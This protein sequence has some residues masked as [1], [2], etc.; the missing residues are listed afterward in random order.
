MS[1]LAILVFS[2]NFVLCTYGV[3][4]CWYKDTLLQTIGLSITAI[5]SAA[6]LYQVVKYE[7]WDHNSFALALGITFYGLGTFIKLFNRNKGI[8]KYVRERRKTAKG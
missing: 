5:A 4:S 7:Y 8:K 3:F 1:T 2:F 6:V